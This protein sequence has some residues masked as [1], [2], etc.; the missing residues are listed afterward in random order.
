[1]CKGRQGPSIYMH[2]YECMRFPLFKASFCLDKPSD[3]VPH[4][5][6]FLYY[7]TCNSLFLTCPPCRLCPAHYSWIC[8]NPIHSPKAATSLLTAAAHLSG[9]LIA[10]YDPSET[11]SRSA[12]AAGATQSSRS[13]PTAVG[14][15][16]VNSNSSGG[17]FRSIG[18]AAGSG[19]G[20]G[21]EGVHPP[22]ALLPEEVRRKMT[23]LPWAQDWRDQAVRISDHPRAML[24]YACAPVSLSACGSL[25]MHAPVCV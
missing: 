25:C 12:H 15:S 16:S 1:M 10:G 11:S 3:L 9:I 22:A 13:W 20:E 19:N 21:R 2:R 23:W 8:T 24:R 7:Y 17:F 14:V 5:A 6:V 4:S 18:M